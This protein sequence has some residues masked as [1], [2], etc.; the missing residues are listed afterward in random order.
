[1][2]QDLWLAKHP[3]LEPIAQ[4]HAQVNAVMVSMSGVSCTLPDSDW[5]L[6]AADFDEGV[7]L[8]YSQSVA[9]D[10]GPVD[11]SLTELVDK[12]ASMQLP[13]KF[14]N[15]AV[16]LSQQLRHDGAARRAIAWLL[17]RVEFD[18]ASPGLLCSLGWALLARDLQPVA[19]TFSA[20]RD[21]ERWLRNYCPMCSASPAMAQLAGINPE[22]LRLLCCGR[23]ATRWRY[24]RTGCP[25]CQNEDDRQL[26]V[27]A[28][29][30]EGG[31]RI[32]YCKS[33]C[34]YLK[35][36]TGEGSE[37]LLLA[38]WTSIHLDVL[39]EDR[40]LKRLA[41]SLYDLQPLG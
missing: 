6:Y 36:Y 30:G 26:A 14:A 33:C 13:G 7:P 39:A 31:L 10:F 32:D 25:F 19:A 5:S 16:S 9:I 22:R 12:L 40:G 37:E 21:E 23:C 41:G 18:C 4:F 17:G 2:T 15:D 11:Q 1:M 28:I 24:R 34:G 20:W 38:D 3:Y 8:L 27:L 35:T 29:D